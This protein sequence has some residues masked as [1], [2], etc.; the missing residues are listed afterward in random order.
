MGG[1]TVSPSNYVTFV[2]VLPDSI[3][4]AFAKL[5]NESLNIIYK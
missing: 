3:M 5:L 4:H 1:D 2:A